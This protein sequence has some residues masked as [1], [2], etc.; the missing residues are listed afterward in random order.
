[1]IESGRLQ[2]DGAAFGALLFLG[3]DRVCKLLVPLR[4]TLEE[5]AVRVATNCGTG[6]M[7]SSTV[8]FYLDWLEG[9]EN[10]GKNPLFG[11]VASGLAIV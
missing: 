4:D 1:M 7:Y 8:D 9:I 3:D 2:N 10:D 5:D 11:L 6:L